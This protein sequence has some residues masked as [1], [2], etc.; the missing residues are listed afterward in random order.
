ME[1]IWKS[2]EFKKES[3]GGKQGCLVTLG[4]LP[5]NEWHEFQW[6][7]GI[8]VDCLSQKHGSLG[9]EAERMDFEISTGLDDGRVETM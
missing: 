6:I 9:T 7:W 2:E 1:K 4:G 3:I 8:M 5:K